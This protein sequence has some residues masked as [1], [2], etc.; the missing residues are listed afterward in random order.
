MMGAPLMPST[1]TSAT[2]AP[3]ADFKEIVFRHSRNLLSLLTHLQT[4]LLVSTYQAGKLALV[5]VRDSKLNLSF[6]NFE[7]PEEIFELTTLPSVTSPSLRGQFAAEV[8]QHA[9]W[10]V[11]R[12][13]QQSDEAALTTS[14]GDKW[15]GIDSKHPTRG[16]T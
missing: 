4:S 12:P 13:G 1:D 10:V 9:I 3:V 14:R 15:P 8:G 16:A 6:H 2:S 7:R 11:P 5:G